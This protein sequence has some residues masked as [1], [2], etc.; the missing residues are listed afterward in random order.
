PT[1]WLLVVSG[2]TLVIMLVMM[3]SKEMT[4]EPLR[5]LFT[6]SWPPLILMTPLLAE[7]LSSLSVRR[8]KESVPP[9]SRPSA[10]ISTPVLSET[11]APEPMLAM[12]EELLGKPESLFQ[13]AGVVQALLPP[14]PIHVKLAA[15]AGDARIAPET[16]ALSS[17]G[18][19]RAAR[20]RRELNITNS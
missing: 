10:L 20:G 11:L 15:A 8:P 5:V 13:L 14:W 16:A 6:F 18:R 9:L 1:M 12:S 3:S 19:R 17:S 7:E 4:P 2:E